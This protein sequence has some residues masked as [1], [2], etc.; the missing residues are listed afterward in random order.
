MN[1]TKW[2]LHRTNHLI[3]STDE[4]AQLRYQLAGQMEESWNFETARETTGELWNSHRN[5]LSHAVTNGAVGFSSPGR[6]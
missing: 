4:R 6:S 5:R 3:T 1:S 2:L